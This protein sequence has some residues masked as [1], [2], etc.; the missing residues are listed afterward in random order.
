MSNSALTVFCTCPDAAKAREIADALVGEKLAACVNIVPGLTSVYR[1]HGNIQADSEVLLIIKTRDTRLRALE[2]RICALH[3]QEVP[4][5]IALPIVDGS[6][7]YL[8]WL[9]EQTL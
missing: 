5:V 2:E 6:A 1:W 4:E 9:Q 7:P 3:P 8:K